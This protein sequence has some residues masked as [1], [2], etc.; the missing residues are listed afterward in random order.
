M[1]D[2]GA[3]IYKTKHARLLAGSKAG[4]HLCSLLVDLGI[5]DGPKAKVSFQVDQ[6][7][8][9]PVDEPVDTQY[10]L[11]HGQI[12][13]HPDKFMT[14]C[15]YTLAGTSSKLAHLVRYI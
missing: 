5:A 12:V 1:V 2:K 9:N 6:D 7:P 13:G 14:Y 10:L 8:D 4:C 15:I 3:I 11:V